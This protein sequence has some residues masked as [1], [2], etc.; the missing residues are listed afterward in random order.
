M[1]FKE[2]GQKQADEFSA[3]RNITKANA[4]KENIVDNIT[5]DA[6]D[7][8]KEFYVTVDAK[9]IT[10]PATTIGLKTRENGTVIADE[11]AGKTSKDKVWAGGDIVT[12]AATVISAMGA[13]KRAAAS[14]DAYL[15]G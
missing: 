9:T 14:I 10:L 4:F 3:S 15:R 12:G 2:Y 7:C 6:Q 13:G 5:L 1:A 11:Q 8:G